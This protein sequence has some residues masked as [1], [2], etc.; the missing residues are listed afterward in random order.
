MFVR[1]LFAISSSSNSICFKNYMR[2]TKGSI[3]PVASAP[4]AITSSYVYSKAYSTA[5]SSRVSYNGTTV[6]FY[7]SQ[8]RSN[9]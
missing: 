6:I 9:I 5:S 7:R 4:I 8:A 2:S 1:K 3:L